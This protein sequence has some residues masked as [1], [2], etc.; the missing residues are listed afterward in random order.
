MFSEV[1]AVLAFVWMVLEAKRFAAFLISEVSGSLTNK[2]DAPDQA[3][4]KNRK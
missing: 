1:L 2:S 3:T 4:E